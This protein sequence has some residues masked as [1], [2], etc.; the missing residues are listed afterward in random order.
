MPALVLEDFGGRSLEGLLGAPMAMDIFLPLAIKISTAVAN[1]HERGVVHKD[2]KPENILVDPTSSEVKVADFGLASRVPREQPPADPPRLIE[3]SLPYLSPEQ[4]GWTNRAIDNRT[5]LYSLGVTFYQMLTGRLPFEAHDPVEWVH[6]HVARVPRSPS[7]LVPE[8]PRAVADIVLKL[9]SK[10]PEDRY[11]SAR[12]LRRDMERSLRQW[13]RSGAIEPFALGRH[14]ATGRLQIPQRL[15]GREREIVRLLEAYGRVVATGTPELLLVSG[16]AGIGKSSLV[17]ELYNPTVR[18]RGLFVSGKFEP[19]KRDI[20][21]STIV[22]TFRE[23]VLDILTESEDRIADWRQRLLA[24][25][26]ANARLMVDVI[27]PIELV[28]GRQP[29]VPELPPAEAQNRFRITLRQFVDV[30]ARREHPLALFLDDLQWAD[31]ASIELLKELVSPSEGS[32]LLVTGAYRES[33]V[34]S[35]H[36]LMLALEDVR[37]AGARLSNIVLGPLSREHLASFVCEVLHCD[38]ARATPLSDLVFEKTAG[39]PFFA[40]QFLTTLH[41]EGLLEF[42]DAAEMFRWDLATIRAKGFT[43]NVVDLMV[44]KLRRFPAATQEALKHLACLG[45]RADV[46]DVALACGASRPQ[47]HAALWE[48]VHAGLVLRETDAYK[49]LHDRVQEAAYALIPEEK[50]PELHLRIGRLVLSRTPEEQIAAAVFDVVSH[51]NRGIALMVGREERERVAELNLLAGERAKASTAYASALSYLAVGTALLEEST[52][53]RRY[54]L[55][56]ALELQRAECEYLT[57]D[58]AGAEERLSALTRRARGLVDVAAVTCAREVLYTTLD[59]SD[60]AVEV[61]L[62]YLACVGIRWSPHPT[63][64]EVRQEY[65]AMWRRLGGSAI[66]HLTELPAATDK[67]SCATM[68]V[69]TWAFGAA[70]FTDENLHCLIVARMTSLSLER[71]NSDGSCYAYIRLGM[72]L[73][74]RFSDYQAGFRFAKVG[75]ELVERR[76]LLRFKARAYLDFGHI[77]IPWTRHMRAGLDLV[78]RSFVTAQETGNLT[79]ASYARNCLITLL[80]AAGD[81]LGEVQREA[82]IALAFVRN[83]KFGLVVDVITVQ[84]MLIRALRGLTPDLSSFDDAQFDE[85]Q[86]ERH[87]EGD[88]GLAIATCWYWIRKLQVRYFGGDYASALAAASKAQPL[89]WT[90]PSFPEVAE[91]HFYRAL[92]LAAHHEDESPEGRRASAEALATH[93]RQLAAWAENSPENFENRVLLVG[94]EIARLGGEAEKA[95]QLYEQAIRSARDN[96]FVQNEALAYEGASRFYRGRGFELF[97]DAYLREARARYLRW[98]ADGKVKQLERLYPQLVERRPFGL[99]ERLAMRSEELDLV[100]VTKASQA[101]SEEIVLHKLLLRLLGVALAHGGAQKGYLVL[102]RER[103]LTVEAEALLEEKG[104]TTR[105]LGSLPVESARR[106]PASLAHYV[107]RTKQRVI[108]DDAASDAGKFSGDEY[109]AGQR[110]KSVLCMPILKQ[111]MVVGVLYLEN[112]LLAGVFTPDRLAALELLAAQAAISLENAWLLTKEQAARAPPRT[113]SAEPRSLPRRARSYRSRWVTRRRW[114]G[115]AGCACARWPTGA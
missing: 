10:M 31:S 93:H 113:R 96:G 36:P 74:P 47:T 3:G 100:S 82:E 22:A 105:T 26:G 61:C 99:N 106:I 94:A 88:S 77:I 56:F 66:E 60:R 72:L 95:A 44:G 13:A 67:T 68:D 8:V 16:Y 35:S 84:R 17:R 97:A 81:P 49:F 76:G 115:S 89:L 18:E 12:G 86:F 19:Y 4:T 91:W 48:A 62:E 15:Y 37:R 1:I 42:D 112:D 107:Q 54:E 5:D 28:T 29:P 92:A 33:D 14:D 85:G 7:E 11:Q 70:L 87:L 39:N 114:T 9:L 38:L 65:E 69:L 55:A 41:E 30:F 110:P 50:R 73:G 83:A 45:N 63:G 80:L 21:Y 58:L 46:A 24:A 103:R 78:R 6:C 34:T 52:W 53:D 40:I 101:I 57:G 27:P 109:F 43:D 59:R 32:F 23:L 79:Y 98:G 102:C 51:L 104:V 75:L 111:A 108:L 20:P 64:D 71:G 25:L 90:S 2:L